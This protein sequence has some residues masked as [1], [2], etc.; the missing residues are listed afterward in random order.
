[1]L[2]ENCQPRILHPVK[3]SIRSEGQIKT[4]LDEGKLEK[5]VTRRYLGCRIKQRV[6]R[7]N[8]KS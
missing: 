8:T 2:Y 5:F 4:F 3:I 6:L 1:M 7:L